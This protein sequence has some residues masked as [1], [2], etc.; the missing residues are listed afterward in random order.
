MLS[1]IL[2]AAGITTPQARVRPAAPRWIAGAA[3][4]L[5]TAIL[6]SWPAPASFAGEKS[7]Y[8]EDIEYALEQIEKECG[9]FFEL[10]EIDWKAVSRQFRKEAERVRSDSEHLVLLKRLLARVRDGHAAIVPLEKG[11]DVE[12]PDAPTGKW[13]GPGFALCKIGKKIYVKHS[14]SSAERAGLEVG[15]QVLAIDDKPV[16]K[17]LDAKIEEVSDTRSFSTDHHAFFFV[18]HGGLAAVQGSRIKLEVKE[19]GGKRSKR[20]ITYSG[21]ASARAQGPVAAPEGLGHAGDISFGKTQRGFGY[22]HIRR[23]RSELP[24]LIDQALSEIGSV[25]G[26]I[27]DFRGNSGG[28]FD[29][30]AVL[31]RFVPEGKSLQFAKTIPSAGSN[32][33]GGP[34]V[35]I[36]DATTVS[37][38]E[39]GSGMFKEDGRAY[40]IGE[41]PTAGMSSQKK[42]I[43]LPSR[44]FGLY[45]S[46]ASNKGRFN[47]GRGIEG[48]GVEPHEIISYSAKDLAKGV[49]TLIEAAERWLTRPKSSDVPYNPG[50]FGWKKP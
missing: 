2:R 24:T 6:A 48:I 20:T 36:V 42:T 47:Q 23:C 40:M 18:T 37:A 28:S 43:E 27:L 1:A 39:T 38:G 33:Y 25:P 49:D 14:W 7:V 17:W 34:V 35:V 19:P 12:W 26:M 45:V 50:Q 3:S 32:P 10:K 30:D 21:N 9:H 13:V 8:E 31:G 22:I 46:I 41:S 11:K 15:S 5:L 44:L 29:H 4:L 16:T